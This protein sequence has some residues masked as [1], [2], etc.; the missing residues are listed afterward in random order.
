[1]KTNALFYA[2]FLS[3][4]HD[5][6]FHEVSRKIFR[7]KCFCW[8]IHGQETGNCSW[9]IHWKCSA[10]KSSARIKLCWPVV[11]LPFI[12]TKHSWVLQG[13]LAFKLRL[14]PKQWSYY[15]MAKFKTAKMQHYHHKQA[16]KRASDENLNYVTLAPQARASGEIL[17]YSLSRYSNILNMMIG[18]K[19]RLSRHRNCK[20]QSVMKWAVLKA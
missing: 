7:L 14:G 11:S 2:A 12:I 16:S 8:I 4:H 15:R 13:A 3:N 5:P 20:W 1:M 9:N 17:N 18:P 19:Y 6:T 10:K